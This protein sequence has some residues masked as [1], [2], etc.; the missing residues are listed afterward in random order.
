MAKLSPE[1]I[2]NYL[3]EAFSE[4][5][6]LFSNWN[7]A[8]SERE[9]SVNG[10]PFT[11]SGVC[12]LVDGYADPMS[13]A[14]VAE[15]TTHLRTSHAA[16]KKQLEKDPSYSTGARCLRRLISDRKADYRYLTNPIGPTKA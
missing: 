11:M 1:P 10:R 8:L 9:V 6:Q 7:P 14:V 16:L 3:R 4:A 13:D 15:L 5:V 12:G 2:P